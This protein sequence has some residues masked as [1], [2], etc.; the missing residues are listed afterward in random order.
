MAFGISTAYIS[1]E[2]DPKKTLSQ[3][4]VEVRGGTPLSILEFEGEKNQILER[5]TTGMDR[6]KVRSG[7]GTLFVKDLGGFSRCHGSQLGCFGTAKGKGRLIGKEGSP[8]TLTQ[9]LRMAPT[10]KRARHHQQSSALPPSSVSQSGHL[11][12]LLHPP[13]LSV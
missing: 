6:K 3:A 12:P 11:L 13:G 5:E 8:L 9:S 4:E 1:V 7:P 10:P 2:R